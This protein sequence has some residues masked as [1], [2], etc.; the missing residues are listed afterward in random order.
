MRRAIEIPAC[1]MFC[2][3]AAA[4]A[5]ACICADRARA[6]D[7]YP[8]GPQ[9]AASWSSDPVQLCA[10]AAPLALVA[11]LASRDVVAS[12]PCLGVKTLDGT[13]CRLRL[14]D[15]DVRVIW[16]RLPCPAHRHRAARA[17]ATCRWR[18]PAR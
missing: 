8:C 4:A 7:A 10:L 16:F 3:L 1:A 18:L 13:S 9:T 5:L 11:G 17:R 15:W 6:S 2:A 14:D 12:Q